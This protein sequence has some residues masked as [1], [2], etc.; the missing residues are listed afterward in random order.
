MK[1]ILLKNGALELPALSGKDFIKNITAILKINLQLNETALIVTSEHFFSAKT[2]NENPLMSRYP[3][4]NTGFPLPY[5]DFLNDYLTPLKALSS[6]YP[7]VSFVLNGIFSVSNVE[8]R[9]L[10]EFLN[11]QIKKWTHIEMLTPFFNQ[12]FSPAKIVD[13][14]SSVTH[15]VDQ[16]QWI[17]DASFII[18][19]NKVSSPIL[20]SGLWGNYGSPASI[21]YEYIN[22]A[23]AKLF[24]RINRATCLK[25]SYPP[26]GLTPNDTNSFWL[27]V[28]DPNQAVVTNNITF[29][30]RTSYGSLDYL[31][32]NNISAYPISK[33]TYT[34]AN[35]ENPQNQNATNPHNSTTLP[36][37]CNGY[38]ENIK[39]FDEDVYVVSICFDNHSIWNVKKIENFIAHDGR[40]DFPTIMQSDIVA[41]NFMLRNI[42]GANYMPKTDVDFPES[43]LIDFNGLA[44]W[45]LAFA[46]LFQQKGLLYA[47]TDINLKGSVDS[48]GL[49][50]ILA[51]TIYVVDR[52][53]GHSVEF[54]KLQPQFIS[55]DIHKY[56]YTIYDFTPSHLFDDLEVDPGL[57]FLF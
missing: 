35:F 45:Q 52:K 49:P 2:T 25:G 15:F 12:R 14:Q 7:N 30:N 41:A 53:L 18:K 56:R 43:F 40:I 44:K 31:N 4:Y 1:Y 36:L 9:E 20:K 6:I 50:E 38:T 33:A 26:T 22:T 21:Y 19:N 51:G 23:G 5:N 47:T 57:D 37:Y 17:F 10:V 8:S 16:T 24:C 27:P 3:C 39:Y 34:S 28:S 32:L 29:D 55:N 42:F 11:N 13:I 48:L 54:K 46:Q